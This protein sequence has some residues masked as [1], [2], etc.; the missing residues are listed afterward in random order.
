LYKNRVFRRVSF[1]VPTIVVGNLQVGG[2][3]KTPMA[4]HLLEQLSSTY[5]PAMISR[6]YGRKTTGFKLVQMHHSAADVGDEPL[7]VYKRFEGNIPVAVGEQRILAI[8][9]L[10]LE[11]PAVD[12]IVLD[13]AYQ[14]L[15]LQ[16]NVYLLLSTF[17]KPFFKDFPFP[18]GFLREGRSAASRAH[19]VVYTKCPSSISDAMVHQ[20]TEE[21]K[22]YAG[23]G[24]EVFFYTLQ[25]EAITPPLLHQSK[26]WLVSGLANSRHFE[27]EARRDMQVKGHSK[28]RDH[29]AYTISDVKRILDDAASAGADAIVTTEKDYVKL[30]EETILSAFPSIKLHYLPVQ[31]VAVAPTT[32]RALP[33]FLEGYIRPSVKSTAD[34]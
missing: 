23:A 3:G 31:C 27:Q 5:S 2:S 20:Y 17:D 7:L 13:D 30:S 32:A 11:H 22:K 21:A 18:A 25:Y 10:L 26:V 9:S 19:A 14:H 33:S 24:V 6:G 4:I 15:P 12:A 8:P 28:F 16:A 29:Y 1:D 34:A